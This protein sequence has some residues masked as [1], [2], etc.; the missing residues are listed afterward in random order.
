M[1]KLFS[2]L[3]SLPEFQAQKAQQARGSAGQQ[4]RGGNVGSSGGRSQAPQSCIPKAFNKY[5][6]SE[7]SYHF[8]SEK[9]DLHFCDD[10]GRKYQN[11]NNHIL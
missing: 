9:I 3:Q 1:F 11:N 6:V 10:P 2:L 7:T 4:A 8:Y 5:D